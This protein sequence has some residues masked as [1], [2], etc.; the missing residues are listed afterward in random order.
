M[1]ILHDHRQP[2]PVQITDQVRQ[3]CEDYRHYVES[4]L[5]PAGEEFGGLVRTDNVKLHQAYSVNLMLAH[6]VDYLH[7]IRKAT[8]ISETRGELVKEFDEKF[9]VDGAYIRNRKM[10]L[11]DAINNALKHIRLAPGRYKK[12]ESEYGKISFK[13]LVQGEGIVICHLDNYRFDYCRVVLLPALDALLGWQ[14]KN[15][16]DVLHFAQGTWALYE[17]IAYSD[18][19]DDD[20]STAIDRMIE[21]CSSP[22]RNCEEDADKCRCSEY[23]FANEEGHYEPLHSVSEEQFDSIMNLISPSYSRS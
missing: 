7:A 6:C 4:I 5:Q 14:F 15:A 21:I 2:L 9:S 18:Y 20:P 12:I 17:T 23:I 11:I 1:A 13:A 16:E 8:G 3:S 22:C 10:E 19:D